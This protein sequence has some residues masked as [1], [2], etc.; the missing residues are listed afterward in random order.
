MHAQLQVAVMAMSDID[1]ESFLLR[2][3]IEGTGE[4]Q[5]QR[6]AGIREGRGP[7]GRRS[8]TVE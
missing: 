1:I 7:R 8:A 3:C 4:P 5:L 2:T 6:S